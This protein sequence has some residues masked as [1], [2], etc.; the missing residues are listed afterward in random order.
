M[1]RQGDVLT[2]YSEDILCSGS[3]STAVLELSNEDIETSKLIERNKKRL[4]W[5]AED[6]F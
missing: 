1:A 6:T 5:Y 3:E 4:S 2:Y